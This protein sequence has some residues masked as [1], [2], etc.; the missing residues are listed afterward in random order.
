MQLEVDSRVWWSQRQASVHCLV[1]N[2]VSFHRQTLQSSRH[3]LSGRLGCLVTAENAMPFANISR[4]SRRA[5]KCMGGTIPRGCP[6]H[7]TLHQLNYS[8]AFESTMASTKRPFTNDDEEDSD[9]T[10]ASYHTASSSPPTPKRQRRVRKT[11]SFTEAVFEQFSLLRRVN[12]SLEQ[13]TSICA[14]LYTVLRTGYR[15]QEQELD[16]FIC[17][18]Q[19]YIDLVSKPTFLL[20]HATPNSRGL[21]YFR[22]FTEHKTPL[23]HQ[24]MILTAKRLQA[25]W[26]EQPLTF[27]YCDYSL[28]AIEKRWS[29]T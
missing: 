23:P 28:A 20:E 26:H 6:A 4:L 9:A 8:T 15:I 16:L 29:Q 3:A 2:S 1:T 27:L 19:L 22:W 12:Y 21:A 13:F 25:I 5:Y 10:T 11:Y 17:N 18:H 7:S 24:P 14:Y